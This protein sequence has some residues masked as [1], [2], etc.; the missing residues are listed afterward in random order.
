[1]LHHNCIDTQTLELLEEIQKVTLFKKLRLVGG[2]SL[3]LQMGHRISVDLDFFGL[4]DTDL[5]LMPKM[6]I[7]V[8]WDEVKK[9]IS[10][11][12]KEYIYKSKS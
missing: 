6:I 5:E 9:T 4:L 8:T 11:K 1:M 12:L 3:A 7:P 10:K 2:T